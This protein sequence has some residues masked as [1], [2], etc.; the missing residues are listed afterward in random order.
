MRS[1]Q[2]NHRQ[3]IPGMRSQAREFQLNESLV[4][5]RARPLRKDF[6]K[7]TSRQ[8]AETGD[9]AMSL[10]F[11][12][13][14][15]IGKSQKSVFDDSRS[16]EGHFVRSND[17]FAETESHLTFANPY[18]T[19][20]I[21]RLRPT[22]CR[23]RVKE[24]HYRLKICD[25]TLA[26]ASWACAIVDRALKVPKRAR[27]LPLALDRSHFSRRSTSFWSFRARFRANSQRLGSSNTHSV[28]PRSG[29]FLISGTSA[30]NVA[31]CAPPLPVTSAMY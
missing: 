5:S 10:L 2:S 11:G 27:H 17:G 23:L 30:G 25:F 9:L 18:F 20:A 15:R 19:A 26:I 28:A 29:G 13:P 3:R 22:E 7:K 1:S 6:T 21:G 31:A 24:S 4:E 8:P 12:R 16:V 14:E